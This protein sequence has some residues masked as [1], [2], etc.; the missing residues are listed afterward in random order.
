[1]KLLSPVRLLLACGVLLALAQSFDV[2]LASVYRKRT[3]TSNTSTGPGY[4]S[5][6]EDKHVRIKG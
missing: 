4:I 1:M 3:R 6:G 5:G 2:L